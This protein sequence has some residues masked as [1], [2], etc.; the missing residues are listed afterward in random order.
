MHWRVESA[1]QNALR[2]EAKLQYVAFDI[3]FAH[4]GDDDHAFRSMATT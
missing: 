4:S 2:S 3:M 1:L